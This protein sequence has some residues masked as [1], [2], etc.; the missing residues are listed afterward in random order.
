MS[1]LLDHP[2]GSKRVCANFSQNSFSGTPCCSAMETAS[3]KL[4]MRP[5]NRGAFLGHLDEEFAG[6]AVGIEADDD[7]AFV[8]SD[9]E[10]VRDRHALFLQLVA[11]GARRSVQILFFDLR[12]AAA[13]IACVIFGGV[14]RLGSG[15]ARAAATACIRR[16]RRLPPSGPASRLGCRLRKYLRP[17]RCS[18]RLTVFEIAPEMKG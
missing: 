8:A 17:W 5:R 15:G 16:D 14:R 7:V 12:R 4:S 18:G 1:G 11:H 3:A 2:L 13:A 10:L 9:V 6:I